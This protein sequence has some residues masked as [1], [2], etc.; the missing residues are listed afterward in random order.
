MHT[1]PG[2]SLY[3]TGQT[4]EN[5]G[6]AGLYLLPLEFGLD[7]IHLIFCLFFNIY[8]I[9]MSFNFYTTVRGYELDSYN[10]LNNAVYL[11]YLE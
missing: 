10:H 9:S 5:L 1:I 2:V 7:R 11:N 6:Q 3:Y 4:F 8:N